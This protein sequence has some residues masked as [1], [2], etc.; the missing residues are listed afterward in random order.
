MPFDPRPYY[1]LMFYS[2]CLILF[3]TYLFGNENGD[4]NLP[5][6]NVR[7]KVTKARTGTVS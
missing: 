2:I 7:D 6:Q 3:C 5:F 4:L 1:K